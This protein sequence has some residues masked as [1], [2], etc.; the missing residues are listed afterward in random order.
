MLGDDGERESATGGETTFNAHVPG[1]TGLDQIVED[2]IDDGFV[3]GMDVA[4]RRQIQLERFGFQA[5]CVRNVFDKNLGEIRLASHGTKRCKIRAIDADGK[6]ALRIRIGKCLQRGLLG[7]FGEG[8]LGVAE[9]RQRGVF[10]IFFLVLHS[11]NII[12]KI[13]RLGEMKILGVI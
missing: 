5:A 13:Y 9:E 7:R 1:V 4:I 11:E 8:G 10:L 3:K 6:I 2:A 12:A